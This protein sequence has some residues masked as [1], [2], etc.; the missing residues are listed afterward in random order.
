MAKLWRRPNSNEPQTPEALEVDI[1]KLRI[2]KPS[3]IFLNGFF[4]LDHN[5]EW[6]KASLKKMED[7]IAHRPDGAPPVDVYSYTHAGLKEA[8]N[9]AA[10]C[11]RPG[12]RSCPIA[13]KLASG[14]VMPL[15][16][17]DFKIGADGKATGTPLPLDDVKKNLR[18][19]TFFGYSA[20]CI[21]AQEIFNASLKMMRQ[22]GYS[23]KDARTALNEVVYIGVGV[24][25]RPGREKDRFTTL[26]LEATNDK[27]VRFKN[28]LWTPLRVLFQRFVHGM[29]I[30]KLGDHAAIITAA[31][32][33]K[34]WETFTVNGT[35]VREKVKNLLPSAMAWI[36]TYHELPRYVTQDEDL[37]PFA[38]MVQFG[39]VNA[40][41]RTG[42]LDPMDLLE[43]PSGTAASTAAAYREKIA[44]AY[45]PSKEL[46]V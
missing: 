6:V 20:G 38:K 27:I 14:I 19:V 23:E 5:F 32:P 29:K 37:S 45:V 9:V 26:F 41:G 18:N 16:A 34:H 43:P 39:L 4:V 36:K 28:R 2:D 11:M 7:L 8:F 3:L 30:K 40:V 24:V 44:N 21:T 22:V 25:S 12:S 13:N 35:T 33:K 17:Q 42:L 31:V 46:K 1:P 15:V 10:Y